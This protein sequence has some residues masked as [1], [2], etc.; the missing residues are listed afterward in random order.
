MASKVKKT[1]PIKSKKSDNV[2]N[3][4][5]NGPAKERNMSFSEDDKFY[6]DGTRSFFW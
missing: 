4:P 6:D 3:G 2:A 1:A 5:T